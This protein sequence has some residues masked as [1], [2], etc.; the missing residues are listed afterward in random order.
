M[1][2]YENRNKPVHRTGQ[3]LVRILIVNLLVFSK[4]VISLDSLSLPPSA[5]KSILYFKYPN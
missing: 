2:I 4:G 1:F 5:T 3:G